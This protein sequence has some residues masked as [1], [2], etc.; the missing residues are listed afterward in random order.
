MEAKMNSNIS[1]ALAALFG[2]IGS[3]LTINLA[4]I[5]WH[6]VFENITHV[7][8]LGLVAGFSGLMGVFGKNVG[9]RILKWIKTKRSK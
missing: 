7:L 8:G 2:I 6:W 4:G 1:D 3:F 5:S 9:E